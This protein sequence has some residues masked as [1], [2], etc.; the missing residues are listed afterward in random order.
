MDCAARD[1]EGL[2]GGEGVGFAVD[3]PGEVALELVDG[4]FVGV[5][6]VSGG[7]RRWEPGTV[8]SKAATLPLESALV[9]R[10]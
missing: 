5:V 4:F 6:A 1:A 8:S 10:K 7:A 3:G 2:A 9:T